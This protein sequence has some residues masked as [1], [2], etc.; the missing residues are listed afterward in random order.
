MEP[1]AILC[2]TRTAICNRDFLSKKERLP[3]QRAVTQ[4]R[5]CSRSRRARPQ[6]NFDLSRVPRRR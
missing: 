1:A 5:R 3:E 2:I 6:A 4:P